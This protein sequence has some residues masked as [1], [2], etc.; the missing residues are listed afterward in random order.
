VKLIAYNKQG[1]KINIKADDSIRC[2]SALTHDL[3]YPIKKISKI[4]KCIKDIPTYL[5]SNQFYS[6]EEY[7]N[8]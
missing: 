4:N 1:D 3:G 5:K 6:K 8:M 7:I 2:I